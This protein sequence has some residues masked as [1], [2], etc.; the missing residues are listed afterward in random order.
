MSLAILDHG[1]GTSDRLAVS[2]PQMN[3]L[4]QTALVSALVILLGLVLNEF[5]H[6]QRYGH[7]APL[8]L[9][10]DVNVTTSDD[11]LGVNGTAKIYRARLTNYGIFPS[12]IVVCDYLISSS[13]ATSLSYV[14][15][16]WD[17]KA[18]EWRFVPEWDYSSRLFC[19]PAFE[20]SEEH[21]ARHRLWPGQGIR[22]GE[23]IPAQMGGFQIGDDGRFTVFLNADGNKKDSIST[24]TFR[25]DQ[26][27]KNRVL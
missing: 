14:V 23:G 20:V 7:L 10:A 15:E 11:V 21:L 12:T 18:R 26:S 8:G 5:Y 27:P 6:L 22:F 2:N 4:R 3:R 9:H 25:V 16:R 19:H 13:P 1:F 24:A 17:R